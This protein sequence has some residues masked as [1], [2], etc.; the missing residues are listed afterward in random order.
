MLPEIIKLRAEQMPK[1][2]ITN[3]KKNIG[4]SCKTR[5][6]EFHEVK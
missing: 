5:H 4:D 3:E 2:Q 1:I 6:S